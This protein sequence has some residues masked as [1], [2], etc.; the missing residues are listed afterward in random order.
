[1]RVRLLP[2]A[3]QGYPSV[4]RSNLS[5]VEGQN[6]CLRFRPYF[7][8]RPS[9]SLDCDSTVATPLTY[10]RSLGPKKFKGLGQGYRGTSTEC[11]NI[12]TALAAAIF[13]LRRVLRRCQLTL[14]SL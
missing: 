1:M 7:I 5:G 4:H 12:F 13:P 11:E 6:I 3:A 8:E 14:G 2:L 9:L 10:S